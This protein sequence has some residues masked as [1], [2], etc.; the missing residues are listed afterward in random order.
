MRDVTL[1]KRS[2]QEAARIGAFREQLVGI[3][4]HDLRNP[5]TAIL[6]ATTL[7]DR[8]GT[9]DDRQRYAVQRISSSA[10]RMQRMISDLL[11]LARTRLGQGL[12]L[13]R[14]PCDLFDIA[15]QVVDELAVAWPGRPIEVQTHGEGRGEWD[16]ERLA[17]VFSNLVGNA[18]Q[19]SR[20]DTKVVVSIQGS[21]T[22]VQ[23]AVQSEGE[24][25]PA[26]VLPSV[27]DAFQRGRNKAGVGV[28]LGLY[29]VRQIV[30]AHGGQV[31]VRSH[32]AEGTTFTVTLPRASS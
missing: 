5:L 4:G 6:A 1:A 30:V 9:L 14:K 7:L 13:S 31:D 29:I 23:L 27:F 24:P 16:A 21:T 26:D 32:P 8:L 28:G 19:H 25:I 10:E 22:G 20:D 18:L 15:R 11:D 12:P 3:V 2:E 17:Q